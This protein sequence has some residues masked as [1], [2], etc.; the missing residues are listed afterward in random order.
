[1]RSRSASAA[2]LQTAGGLPGTPAARQRPGANAPVGATVRSGA[3]LDASGK[4][5]L[6]GRSAGQRGPDRRAPA[7]STGPPRHRV[8][9]P[10]DLDWRP[11]PPRYFPPDE[12]PR[13]GGRPHERPRQERWEQPDALVVAAGC[14]RIDRGRSLRPVG[15][16]CSCWRLAVRW[17]PVPASDLSAHRCHAAEVPI[18]LDR[19][20][21]MV[22]TFFPASFKPRFMIMLCSQPTA[23][24]SS[25]FLLVSTR[26][27]GVSER[28]ANS[29]DCRMCAS[30]S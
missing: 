14:R 3:A 12:G 2:R 7:L 22:E 13:Q 20:S 28:G 21:A 4:A 6:R 15:S 23:G 5:V 30:S 17:V 26:K 10:A 27:P 16:R 18:L 1:M 29:F 11:I 25:T 19:Y 8:V 9:A 24:P